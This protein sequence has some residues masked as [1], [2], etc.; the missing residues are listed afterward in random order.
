MQPLSDTSIIKSAAASGRAVSGHTQQPGST[1]SDGPTSASLA[2]SRAWLATQRPAD[3]DAKIRHSLTSELNVS[4]MSAHSLI[5]KGELPAVDIG[6]GKRKHWRIDRA[7][8][9]AYLERKRTETARQ[10]GGAA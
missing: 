5:T 8:F 7:D 6:T 2:V 10:Y 1:A 3:V 4:V 9:D